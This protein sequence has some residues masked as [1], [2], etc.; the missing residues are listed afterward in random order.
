MMVDQTQQLLEPVPPLLDLLFSSMLEAV[1][2]HDGKKVSKVNP[3]ACSLTGYS[4]SELLS[5]PLAKLT[6]RKSPKLAQLTGAGRVQLAAK[7]G[8]VIEALALPASPSLLILKDVSK[9]VSLEVSSSLAESLKSN[10][11][12]AVLVADK[13]GRITDANPS[14][15]KLFGFP[16]SELREKNVSELLSRGASLCLKNAFKGEV[17][18]K[19][20]EA[21]SKK[22]KLSVMMT[23]APMKDSN[24]AVCILQDLSEYKRLTIEVS[25]AKSDYE[26]LVNNVTDIL[27][28]IDSGGKF[29]YSNYQLKKQLGHDTTQIE[30][31]ITIIHPDDLRGFLNS[32]AECQKG[33][34]SFRDLEF[35]ICNSKRKWFYYSAN[36]TP[37][38]DGGV[39]TGFRGIMRNITERKMQEKDTQRISEELERKNKEL[40]ELNRV[41]SDFVSNV[42]HELKTPLTNIQGYSSLLAT[43]QLGDLS[44]DQQDAAMVI[45][46]ESLRLSR[47]IN[48]ILDIS[49]LEAGAVNVNTRPFLLSCLQEKCSCSSLAE[50]KGLTVF[51]N[52]PDS[53]GE[54]FADPEKISQVITNLVSNAI[55]FTEHG[56]VTVNAFSKDSKTIQIDV[57]DTGMGISQQDQRSLFTRFYQIRQAG[58]KRE[59]TGLGL[60]I[61]KEIVDLHGQRIWAESKQ[62]KG[63]KFSFTIAK[64]SA[65]EK[66]FR[67]EKRPSDQ[68]FIVSEPAKQAVQEQAK[69]EKAVEQLQVV[70]SPKNEEAVEQTVQPRQEPVI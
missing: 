12:E 65:E 38:K 4:E 6:S 66:Q 29:A 55:K 9:E 39:V 13:G 48:D 44:A 56:S 60:A 18:R 27:F 64:A 33:G 53:L 57:I 14:A 8:G 3:A 43:K 47:L 35:R 58:V 42:S 67:E 21:N 20:V 70:E 69:Q 19:E 23:I 59:G 10:S 40:L 7:D 49:K 5:L 15:E 62:G 36:A 51:W 25:R 34:K 45:H 2:I 28:V 68:S 24:L 37:I 11:G 16:S 30:S 50:R 22:S 54:I 63:S 52:T 31:I 26:E 41:K 17:V 61:C 32:L 46:K 1:V